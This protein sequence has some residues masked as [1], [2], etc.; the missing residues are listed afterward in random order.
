MI[1]TAA[2][3]ISEIDHLNKNV[4]YNYIDH[5]NR[6]V[7][8]IVRIER[9]EGP[10]YIRRGKFT[11]GAN[12]NTARE[13]SISA[14]MIWRVANAIQ[15]DIPVNIDRIVGASYNTRSVL[16]SLLAYTPAFYLTYPGRIE[17][18]VSTSKIKAGHKH[19]IWMPTNPH[20]EGV[21]KEFVTTKVIS[22]I[23][24]QLAIY[25]SLA[26]TQASPN[27]NGKSINIEVE[28]RHT[29]IQIALFLIGRQLGF[30][31]WIAQ[32]D[33]NIVYNNQKLGEMD[34]IVVSLK[35]EQLLMSYQ[36]AIKAALLIDCIW[37]KNGRLM[38][39]IMEVEHSTSVTS[40][41][42]RMK[43]F[44]DKFPPFPTRYVIVA[45][46]E[47]RKKVLR[48]CGK[49]QFRDLNP[50]YFPYSSVEEL[51]S[52][53]QRRKLKGVTEDFLDCFMEKTV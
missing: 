22:E 42:S 10:I 34:G 12:V 16:E 27:E 8:K 32:N 44:K 21:L 26:I 50:L 36:D 45:P 49:A 35:E 15:E 11:A 29:Q 2:N 23:P 31:T 47:D 39:A 9:P 51:Y 18:N 48:N 43:N 25:E 6:N 28:R 19:L 33:K 52:L 4:Y 53:C 37:F 14:N 40:G 24:S 3:I 46:D 17:N 1:I 30:R 38:P 20:K 13:I 41:L 5:S 7:I